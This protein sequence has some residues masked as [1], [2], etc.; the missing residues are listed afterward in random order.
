V[1][2]YITKFVAPSQFDREPFGTRW[3]EVNEGVSKYFI[4]LS[5]DINNPEWRSLGSFFECVFA[6]LLE[7]REFMNECLRLY[8]YNKDK[9]YKKISDIIKDK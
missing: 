4:Q 9:P 1:E 3:I 8:S 5:E 7:D 2:E 6:D